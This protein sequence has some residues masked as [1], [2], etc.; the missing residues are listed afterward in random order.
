M[1]F[2]SHADLQSAASV[3]FP[4]VIN[5]PTAEGRGFSHTHERT[6]YTRAH[7]HRAHILAI[8]ECR[9]K[10]WASAE[11]SCWV[12]AKHSVFHCAQGL[13]QPSRYSK[14]CL[15]QPDTHTDTHAQ[16]HTGFV[17]SEMADVTVCSASRLEGRSDITATKESFLFTLSARP[18][19]AKGGRAGWE[20]C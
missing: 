11:G 6:Q 8:P 10:S 13:F 5:N 3:Q 19:L 16:T 18:W 4:R 12:K 14:L 20:W 2:F 1:L 15:H 9:F 17:I 7:S